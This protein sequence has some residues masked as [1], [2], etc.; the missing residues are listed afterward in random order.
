MPSYA[1]SIKVMKAVN[2]QICVVIRL[3]WNYVENVSVPLPFH[4]KTEH[5]PKENA[6]YIQWSAVLFCRIYT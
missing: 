6:T 1:P 2:S 5:T 3:E 4:Y